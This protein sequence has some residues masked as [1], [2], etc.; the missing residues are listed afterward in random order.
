MSVEN[1]NNFR[2]VFRVI[3][4]DCEHVED[5]HLLLGDFL[6]N[7]YGNLISS[8]VDLISLSHRICQGCKNFIYLGFRKLFSVEEIRRLY[9]G[10]CR[11]EKEKTED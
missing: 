4:T 11:V 5:F 10:I 2:L 6:F 7:I 8:D 3:C 1:F 9:H